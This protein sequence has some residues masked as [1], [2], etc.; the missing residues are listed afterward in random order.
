MGWLV[1][2]LARAAALVVVLRITVAGP[3]AAA[4]HAIE[5]INE[6]GAISL[7]RGTFAGT[8]LSGL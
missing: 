3:A 4:G 5:G 2:P 1:L 6:S 8:R 7:H